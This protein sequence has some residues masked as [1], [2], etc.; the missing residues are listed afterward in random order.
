MLSAVVV[1]LQFDDSIVDAVTTAEAISLGDGLQNVGDANRPVFVHG[2]SVH[3]VHF[4]VDN[5]VMPGAEDAMLLPQMSVAQP[6]VAE[7]L[8]VDA[9]D[10]IAVAS[11]VETDLPQASREAHIHSA[12]VLFSFIEPTSDATLAAL[13]LATGSD[14]SNENGFPIAQSD[15]L[16]SLPQS[17]VGRD[18]SGA[19]EPV[20]HAAEAGPVIVVGSEL[21]GDPVDEGLRDLRIIVRIDGEIADAI[22]VGEF[23]KFLTTVRAIVMMATEAEPS[24]LQWTVV[25]TK[26]P[27]RSPGT[28]AILVSRWQVEPVESPAFAVVDKKDQP[29]PA[30]APVRAAIK[31]QEP[32]R[33]TKRVG[34]ERT[35]ARPVAGAIPPPTSTHDV[36]PVPTRDSEG[37][38]ATDVLIVGD[39]SEQ[40]VDDKS[41][42]QE[43]SPPDQPHAVELAVELEESV[44][45]V[46]FASKPEYAIS[47]GSTGTD[48]RLAAAWLDSRVAGLDSDEPVPFLSDRPPVGFH[49]NQLERLRFEIG[50]RGPPQGES[51]ASGFAPNR[52]SELR[53]KLLRHRQAPR[54]PSVVSALF[55]NN[56]H[57]LLESRNVR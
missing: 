36:A 56:Q 38:I 43:A 26:T 35:P 17:T 47:V 39:E 40:P 14:A 37:L 22:G 34:I 6:Q 46:G 50:P 55:G 20:A 57:E 23:D 31:D 13:P 3:Y 24:R 2:D 28:L 1:D 52:I 16:V 42:R 4:R 45:A 33:S 8:E 48:E 53:L 32:V 5:S 12:P 11:S 51:V 25:R 9:T 44:G 54:S 15:A 49:F 30:H 29:A 41:T 18:A 19:I 27:R 21:P 7:P 10:L